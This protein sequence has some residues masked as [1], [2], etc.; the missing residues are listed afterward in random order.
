MTTLSSVLPHLDEHVSAAPGASPGVVE[1]NEFL[2]RELFN[3]QHIDDDG[4][5]LHTAISLKDLR[6]RGFSVNRIGYVSPDFM[7]SSVE[8]RLSRPRRGKPWRDEG[9]A[10][11]ETRQV[12]RFR[13][14]GD[15]AFA[16][17]DTALPENPGH[18]SIYVTKPEKGEAYARELRSLLLPLLQDR[19]TIE[20]AF[21]F[22]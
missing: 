8:E 16:V 3:P 22:Q 5:V 11:L 14:E 21:D 13:T 7:R 9:V 12:R 1:N 20:Q 2:L 17:I 4:Q 19:M 10:R 18:A 15:Q 6:H